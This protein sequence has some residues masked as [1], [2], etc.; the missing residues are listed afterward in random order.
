MK[1][2]ELRQKLGTRNE[3]LR[4]MMVGRPMQLPKSANHLF[5]I[6]LRRTNH[7]KLFS[8]P[9]KPWHV[10][11]REDEQKVAAKPSRKKRSTIDPVEFVGSD[12]CWD[13]RSPS[14]QKSILGCLQMFFTR[15][16]AMV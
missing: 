16:W 9:D 13:R 12:G 7:L 4:G 10:S 2:R 1:N 11:K 15:P 8:V 6:R 14:A 5:E 3:D